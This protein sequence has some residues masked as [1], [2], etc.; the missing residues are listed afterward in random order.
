MKAIMNDTHVAP[1]HEVEAFLARTEA[2]EF[3]FPDATARYAWA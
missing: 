3:T 1:F 2:V